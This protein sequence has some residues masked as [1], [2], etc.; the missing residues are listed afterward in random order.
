MAIN[1][2][3]ANMAGYNNPKIE[4]FEA[5]ANTDLEITAAP[6]QSEIVNSLARGC[7]PFIRLF[8]D[9]GD[10]I[11]Q[12]ILPFAASLEMS[13]HTQISFTSTSSFG[14]TEGAQTVALV[15]DSTVNWPPRIV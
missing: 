3:A 4:V 8:V 13:Q 5:T 12:F 6:K 9:L 11:Q 10:S 14:D 1:F 2:E 15:Y 7:I